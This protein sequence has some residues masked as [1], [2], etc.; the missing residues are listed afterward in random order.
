MR[1]IRCTHTYLAAREVKR[2][3]ALRS[4]RREPKGRWDTSY[5]EWCMRDGGV[6]DHTNEEEA[7]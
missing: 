5:Y 1:R 7:R 6:A 3:W 2:S 4:P